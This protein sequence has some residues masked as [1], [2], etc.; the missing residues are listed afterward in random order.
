MIE[1]NRCQ[2]VTER[3]AARNDCGPS[4]LCIRNTNAIG[5]CAPGAEF[6]KQARRGTTNRVADDLVNGFARVAR[7][8]LGQ[9]AT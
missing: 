6:P 7:K 8:P 3:C 9:V 5:Y 1:P 2:V 4:E